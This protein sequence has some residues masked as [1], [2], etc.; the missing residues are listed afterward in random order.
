MFAKDVMINRALRLKKIRKSAASSKRAF[1]VHL[2]DA[3]DNAVF[4]SV[5]IYIRFIS[6]SI[7][8]LTE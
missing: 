2:S 7:S 6:F 8:D 4:A 5:K 1:G 3:L